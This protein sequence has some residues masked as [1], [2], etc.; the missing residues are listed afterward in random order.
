METPAITPSPAH[1][2]LRLKTQ[3]GRWVNVG[4]FTTLGGARRL[5]DDLLAEQPP[6]VS[7]ARIA[8]EGN[9]VNGRIVL[10]GLLATPITLTPVLDAGK[11]TDWDYLGMGRLDQL[12]SGRLSDPANPL[13]AWPADFIRG[14]ASPQKTVTKPN[15]T[16]MVPPGWSARNRT[17]PFTAIWR[18]A[19]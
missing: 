16:A 3:S 11:L 4:P 6:V 18:P 13:P 15:T 2:R 17:V 9:P 12:L 14:Q 10:R 19:T 8:L 7:R 5:A 1:V